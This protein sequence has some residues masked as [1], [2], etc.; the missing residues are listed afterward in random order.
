LLNVGHGHDD[1]VLKRRRF[2]PAYSAH[3]YVRSAG[4]E[5]D[6]QRRIESINNETQQFVD[7]RDI[8]HG[9]PL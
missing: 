8:L 3:H 4:R 6:F 1:F 7:H 9:R 5:L 2:D